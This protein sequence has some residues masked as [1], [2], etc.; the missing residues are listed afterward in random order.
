MPPDEIGNRLPLP[1]S[2]PG[3]AIL[4]ARGEDEAK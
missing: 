2:S 4:A 1:I 3:K